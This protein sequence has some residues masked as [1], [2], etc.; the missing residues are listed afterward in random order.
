MN[1]STIEPSEIAV[2]P[3][4]MSNIRRLEALLAEADLG[5]LRQALSPPLSLVVFTRRSGPV[6]FSLQLYAGRVQVHPGEAAQ[7][8]SRIGLTSRAFSAWLDGSLDPK[9]ALN[10]GQLAVGGDARPFQQLAAALESS[11]STPAIGFHES[12]TPT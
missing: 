5:L 11:R 7:P 8:V 3:A 2:D 6:H 1:W 12:P 10:G 9:R 4:L